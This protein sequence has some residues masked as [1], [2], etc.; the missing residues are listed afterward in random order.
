MF[1]PS[2]VEIVDEACFIECEVLASLVFGSPSHLRELLSLPPGLRG[3]LAIPNSV[4]ILT[5][6]RDF[7][8]PSGLVLTFGSDSR[9]SAVTVSS[10]EGRDPCR[11]FLQVSSRTL[12]LFRREWEFTSD[13]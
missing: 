8:D 12:K 6:D 9:L 11:A 13:K 5:F 4:E 1:L 3:F 2:T 7:T 10:W